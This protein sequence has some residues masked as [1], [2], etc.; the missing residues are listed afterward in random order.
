VDNLLVDAAG[1]GE[2]GAEMRR[3]DSVQRR[4]RDRVEVAALVPRAERGGELGDP[5]RVQDAADC[6]KRCESSGPHRIKR[7]PCLI[8]HQHR[9]AKKYRVMVGNPGN[10]QQAAARRNFIS[11]IRPIIRSN[12]S[13]QGR[14]LA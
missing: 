2:Q 11:Y 8:F 3:A 10:H 5:Q 12:S 9:F 4:G 7:T 1:H 14:R 6:R 13:H